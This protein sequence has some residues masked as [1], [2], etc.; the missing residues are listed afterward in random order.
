MKLLVVVLLMSVVC[1][2]SNYARIDTRNSFYNEI[3]KGTEEGLEII[4]QYENLK[5]DT[6]YNPKVL[7]T[8]QDN[9][10]SCQL[11]NITPRHGL[12]MEPSYSIYINNNNDVHLG[13]YDNNKRSCLI[14]IRHPTG[15]QIL[16]IVKYVE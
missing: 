10:F 11:D 8:K 1:F 4:V 6:T 12:P 14:V 2:A 5:L 13:Y 9:L 15:N 7:I 16:A 3:Q